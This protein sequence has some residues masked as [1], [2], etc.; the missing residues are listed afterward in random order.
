LR[1]ERSGGFEINDPDYYRNWAIEI[2]ALA[3]AMKHIETQAKTMRLAEDYD[4]LA[5]RAELRS[6]GDVPPN[7]LRRRAG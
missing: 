3:G 5:E 4:K 2:R 7:L 6:N 1:W